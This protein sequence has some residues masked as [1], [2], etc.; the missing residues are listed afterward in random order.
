[1]KSVGEFVSAMRA[2]A[3]PQRNELTADQQ[4][5]LRALTRQL[6][7]ARPEAI[8]ELGRFRQVTNRTVDLPDAELREW[9]ADKTILVT[10]GTGCIGSV[11]I[12]ELVR[13]RP[14]RLTSLSRGQT[15]NWRTHPGV[16]YV[17]ADI[18]CPAELASAFGQVR[19]D[20][21]FHLAAQR[22]PGLAEREVLL[23]VR[24]NVLGMHNVVTAC[25]E[26][27]VPEL[28]AATTGKALRPYS[29]EVYTAGKRAAEWVLAGA[30][31][32]GMR[33]SANRFTHVVDN[34]IVATRLQSWAADDG[35]IRVHDPDTMFYAQS[36]RESA[37]LMLWGGLRTRPGVLHVSAINDLG[38]PIS[39]LD[40]AIGIVQEADSASPIYLSG[41][42]P[43]YETV[44]FPGLY[45]PATSGDVSPLLSAFE[46]HDA[47]HDEGTG[48]D[49]CALA[50]DHS[51]V[52]ADAL[53]SLEQACA[54]GDAKQVN[55][56]LD[57]LSW[58][59]FDAT[60]AEVPVLTLRRSAELTQ[61][62][63]ARL[64]CDHARMYSGIRQR[65]GLD[66]APPVANGAAPNGTV[67]NGAGRNGPVPNGTVPN[68]AVPAQA[69]LT[70]PDQPEPELTGPGPVG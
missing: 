36:A 59:L 6:M 14:G 63:A 2:V 17:Q 10:G 39:L 22:D 25:A 18:S 55:A 30:A 40:F 49:T 11:L 27:G 28:V 47:W 31:R 62:F 54:D 60:L 52:P 65:A 68:G 67:P 57:E 44:P 42:D 5:E 33:V 8:A 4:R 9:L 26:A 29:R 7:A 13:L 41:H 50:F 12:E 23:T 32:Q 24:T 69:A 48:I 58:H 37:R 3:P 1:V 66:P 38:W 45:D 15:V 53:S 19:P 34:S 70:R 64:T 51:R 61:P 20:L 43:G 16:E 21:V 35:I 46:A 56:R